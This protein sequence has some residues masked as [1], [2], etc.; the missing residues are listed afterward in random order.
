MYI[1]LFSYLCHQL[2][3]LFKSL[4]NEI[5]KLKS[6]QDKTAFELWDFTMKMEI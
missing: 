2:V 5:I 1:D 6:Q 4:Y 3:G